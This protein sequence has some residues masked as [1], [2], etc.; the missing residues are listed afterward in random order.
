MPALRRAAPFVAAI[1]LAAGCASGD[2]APETASDIAELDGVLGAP[3]Q[4][5]SSSPGFTAAGDGFVHGA[6]AAGQASSPAGSRFEARLDPDGTTYVK[7]H[8]SHGGVRLRP[9]A[10]PLALGAPRLRDGAVVFPAG[11]AASVVLRAE[12]TRLKED[13]VLLRARGDHLDLEWD[14]LV[15]DGLEARLEGGD[16][17]VYGAASFLWG[18]VQAADDTSRE[19]LERARQLAPRNQLLYRIPAPVIRM[20][21][22]REQSR[23]LRFELTGTRLR[24]VASGLNALTYPLS[25]DPTVEVTLTADFQLAGQDEG[26]V[27]IANDQIARDKMQ[28][29]VGQWT[30]SGTSFLAARSYHAASAHGGYLYV[31]GGTESDYLNGVKV[32]VINPDGTL[33]ALGLAGTFAT[34]RAEHGG[35]AYNGYYYVI[36]GRDATNTYGDVQ[37]AQINATDGTLGAFRTLSPLPGLRR[38]AGVVAY[39]GRIYVTGGSD[40]TASQKT[41]FMATINGDGSLGT[42]ST[43]TELPVEL[44]AHGAVAWNGWLYVVG[45]NAATA[46]VGDVRMAPILADGSLGAWSSAATFASPRGY[47]GVLAH[48]GHLYVIGGYD[49]TAGFAKYVQVAPIFRSGQLGAWHPTTSLTNSHYQGAAVAANGWIYAVGGNGSTAIDY[50][51]LDQQGLLG[52][53]MTST[54]LPA[55]RSGH[56][57]VV[58]NGYLYVIGG[59]STSGVEQRDVARIAINADGSLGPSWTTQTNM[60][61]EARQGISAAAWNGNIYVAGGYTTGS[62]TVYQQTVVRAPVSATDGSLTSAFG[63]AV[64]MGS[65]RYG[66]GAFAYAGYFYLIGG[67]D[68][69]TPLATT[70]YALVNSDGTLSGF[71]PGGNLTVAVAAPGVA[72]YRGNV[73]ATGGF[74]GGTSWSAVVQKATLNPATG[75]LSAFAAAGMVNLP[76]ARAGHGCVAYNGYLYVLGGTTALL[77]YSANT[78]YIPINADGTLSS[79]GWLTGPSFASARTDF[80]T[81]AWNGYVYTT[82]GTITAAPNRLAETRIG[83][84]NGHGTLSAWTAPTSFFT[85]RFLHAAVATS[86]YIYVLGGATGTAGA[87]QCSNDAPFVPVNP[88]GS[89]GPAGSATAFTTARWAHA[90]FTYNNRVYLSGGID[91]NNSSTYLNDVRGANVDPSTG[92]LTWLPATTALPSTRFGHAHAVWN[93]LVY[94]LGGKDSTATDLNTVHYAPINADGTLG[95][96]TATT[97]FSGARRYLRAFAHNGYLYV[98]GGVYGMSSSMVRFNDVQVAPLDPATGAVGTWTRLT[99]FDTPRSSFVAGIVDGYL[100]VAGG[101][102]G[103]GYTPYAQVAPIHSDGNIGSW[104]GTVPLPEERGQTTAV[105]VNGRFYVL[106]GSTNSDGDTTD[107]RVAYTLTPA[108]L[109]RYTKLLSFPESSRLDN[110]SAEGGATYGRANLSYAVADETGVLGGWIGKGPVPLDGTLVLLGDTYA[111]SMFVEL[112]LDDTHTAA[113]NPDA[114]GL[115]NVTD[116]TVNSTPQCGLTSC[117]NPAPDDCHQA[118]ACNPQTGHCYFPIQPDTTSCQDGNSCTDGDHCVSGICTAG[119][120]WICDGGPPDDGG[121]PDGGLPDGGQHDGGG[122]DAAAQDDGATGDGAVK[123]ETKSYLSC[124]CSAAGAGASTATPWLLL[125]GLAAVLFGRRRGR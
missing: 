18:D 101:A 84:I 11:A 124:D 42:W 13:I 15:D 111:R 120:V 103:T 4:H 80:G 85:Q 57:S 35:V 113:V 6:V 1:V 82:G 2:L 99:P 76:S 104:T 26:G 61:P 119:P 98:L 65:R 7:R 60:L 78:Y 67:S 58:Y 91:C 19:R 114:V 100:Y 116:F 109:G 92:A 64:T 68:S 94:L 22:G 17:N 40:G 41:V 8:D 79:G 121:V 37:V 16:V 36:G 75:A 24:L 59:A 32:A 51:P 122:S 74:T 83:L 50:A 33:G 66:A 27:R 71:S 63:D 89:L 39:R 115:R 46:W 90:A 56:A 96:W 125:V 105:V 55:I 14:L 52:G 118:E 108:P 73:Y 54:A 10:G 110:F 23:G 93:G 43:A 95:S 28:F 20:A 123:Q 112:I 86:N 70:E 49:G 88:D 72:V 81:A 29:G 9:V 38:G 48:R 47:A 31:S 53:L 30:Q 21:D 3:G 97:S 12:A 69:G 87:G 117:T 106:G 45:G 34:A 44:Y 102:V 5:D 77:T 25:I 62:P 107:V